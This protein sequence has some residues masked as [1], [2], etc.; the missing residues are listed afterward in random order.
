MVTAALFDRFDDRRWARKA[1]L[2]SGLWVVL[3]L[4]TGAAPWVAM[5][6]LQFSLWQ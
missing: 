4:L 5:A 1:R 3:A 2:S 6:W